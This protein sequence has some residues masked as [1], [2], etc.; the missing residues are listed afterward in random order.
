M[1]EGW[2]SAVKMLVFVFHETSRTVCFAAESFSI[3]SSCLD[4]FD[5]TLFEEDSILFVTNLLAP[6]RSD[7]SAAESFWTKMEIV[8]ELQM[9]QRWRK[10]KKLTANN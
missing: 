3:V 2:I 6:M 1:T 7:K 10:L 5:T 9:H 4:D 8:F